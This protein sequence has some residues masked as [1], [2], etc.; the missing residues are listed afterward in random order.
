MRHLPLLLLL[1]I[2]FICGDY[3]NGTYN[4]LVSCSADG[5]SGVCV[6]KTKD[7]CTQG[8]FVANHCPGAANIECCVTNWGGCTADGKSGMCLKTSE[9]HGTAVSG[10]CPGPSNV[11]CC[12]SGAPSA[13][14]NRTACAKV[15]GLWHSAK[16]RYNW[17]PTTRQFVSSGPGLYRSDC[18]GFV[19]AAWDFSAPGYVVDNI[20]V[21][22]I[23][24][25]ELVQCDALRHLGA[26]TAG[27]IALF[28]GWSGNNPIVMEECGHTADCCGGEHTCPGSCGDCNEYCPGCPIQL[29]AWAGL[30]GFQP[31]RR[32]GW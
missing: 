23:A 12:I 3:I 28:W 10:H 26:G 22:N 19:S 11:E 9:C 32:N 14:W 7:P 5:G 15:A 24:A 27:H 1:C 25:S 21:H 31:V 29:R 8:I 18:S 20:P 2:P 17:N 13:T 30:R 6:D 4:T 16:I